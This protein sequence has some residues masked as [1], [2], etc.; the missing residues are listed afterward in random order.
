[1]PS[2]VPPMSRCA[3][4]MA[5]VLLCAIVLVPLRA[6]GQAAAADS[7]SPAAIDGGRQI[8]HGA[9]NCQLC[10]GANLEG[11]PIAPTLQAHAW[12]DAKGGG[13][14]AIVGVV[15]NGVAG[16]AMVGHPG[17]ISDADVRKVAAYVWAVSHGKGKP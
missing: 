2:S 10:H 5:T 9:A 3:A 14:D 16:T 13:Y 7:L 11:T 15:T 1:M 6:Q 8:F 4:G 17:G 12:K